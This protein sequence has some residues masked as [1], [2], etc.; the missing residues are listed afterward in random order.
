MPT[1]LAMGAAPKVFWNESEQCSETGTADCRHKYVK[2]FERHV[3]PSAIRRRPAIGNLIS[4]DFYIHLTCVQSVAIMSAEFIRS[5]VQI[6][7]GFDIR[8]FSRGK[9]FYRSSVGC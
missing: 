9:D 1:R 6:N 5:F 4:Y 3:L 2:S 7:R 8:P